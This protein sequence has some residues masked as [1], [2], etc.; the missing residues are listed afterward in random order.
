MRRAVQECLLLKVLSSERP[1]TPVSCMHP[2][3]ECADKCLQ[4]RHPDWFLD[5]GMTDERF[6][7]TAI[8]TPH[9]R[10]RGD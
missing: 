2:L 6:Q 10:C 5:T 4:S 8:L 1:G 9:E 7:I 3:P